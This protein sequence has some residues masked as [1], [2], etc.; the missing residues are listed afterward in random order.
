MKT[1]V[2]EW[3]AFI[4]HATEDKESF[5]RELAQKLV[6]EGITVWYDEFTLQVGDSL[7]QS[8]DKGLSNSRYGIVVLSHSFFRKKWPKTELD[9]LVTRERNGEKVILPIWLDVDKEDVARYSIT[10]ADRVAAK[11]KEGIGKV[12]AQLLPILRSSSFNQ[13]SALTEGKIEVSLEEEKMNSKESIPPKLLSTTVHFEEN[14]WET[15]KGEMF[16][17]LVNWVDY[18]EIE[19]TFF[20]LKFPGG[21]FHGSQKEQELTVYPNKLPLEEIIKTFGKNYR[22]IKFTV[23]KQFDF[24]DLVRRSRKGIRPIEFLSKKTMTFTLNQERTKL[25]LANTD[26]GCEIIINVIV[27]YHTFSSSKSPISYTTVLD[28]LEKDPP[29]NEFENFLRN[30][31]E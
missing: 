18:E 16:A 1:S 29:T 9:G 8:I 17:V 5:V 4:C 14:Y 27:P 7:R 2:F 30:A 25:T 24:G 3:D 19:D 21:L 20:E 26:K 6:R 23:D 11:A 28:Y 22:G 10:L 15:I 13:Q 12:I 31:I